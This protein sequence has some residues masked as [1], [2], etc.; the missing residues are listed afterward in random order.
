MECEQCQRRQR[1]FL[2]ALIA[3]DQAETHLRSYFLTHLKWAGVS[4]LDEYSALRRQQEQAADALHRR[5]LD[6]V[7]HGKRHGSEA[8]R[9]SVEEM[10]A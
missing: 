7:E 2:E 8:N 3:A 5:Y 9:D 1:M 4:D 10:L 6:L